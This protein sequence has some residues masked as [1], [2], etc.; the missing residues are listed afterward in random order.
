MGLPQGHSLVGDSKTILSPLDHIVAS[1][2]STAKE[3]EP[4]LATE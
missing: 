1:L 4:G 2:R 3:E